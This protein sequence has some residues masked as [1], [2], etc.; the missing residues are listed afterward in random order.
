MEKPQENTFQLTAE[1]AAPGSCQTNFSLQ[2]GM[3]VYIRAKRTVITHQE[4]IPLKCKSRA[5]SFS[6]PG[7]CRT[8]TDASRF[9]NTMTTRENTT[10]AR[11]TIR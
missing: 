3:N 5:N 6:I 8:I 2:F 10:M 7:T 9:P 1:N 4:K 11:K